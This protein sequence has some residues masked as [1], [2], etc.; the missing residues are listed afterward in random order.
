MQSQRSGNASCDLPELPMAQN[1][2]FAKLHQLKGKVEQLSR[3]KRQTQVYE[4]TRNISQARRLAL[5]RFT[6]RSLEPRKFI[7]IEVVIA[8]GQVMHFRIFISHRDNPLC[9]VSERIKQLTIDEIAHV[10][11]ANRL[12][13]LHIVYLV[14][15][16]PAIRFQNARAWRGS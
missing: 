13:I 9:P 8:H 15:V 14:E 4:I 7:P 1:Y 3:E 10:D 5:C 16:R 11:R 12:M 6:T 2:A